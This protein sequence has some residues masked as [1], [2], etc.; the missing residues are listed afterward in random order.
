[1]MKGMTV[2]LLVASELAACGSSATA[3]HVHMEL[4]GSI[5]IRAQHRPQGQGR[6]E[7]VLDP[8]RHPGC[9]LPT[10]TLD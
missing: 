2:M 4:G 8:E 6:G 3:F 1:M 9:G 10:S 5:G 7:P